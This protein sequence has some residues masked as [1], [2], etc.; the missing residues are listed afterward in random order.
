MGGWRVA[1]AEMIERVECVESRVLAAHAQGGPW[2]IGEL[3][4]VDIVETD[5]G[6]FRR[7]RDSTFR[8]LDSTPERLKATAASV[9]QKSALE[10]FT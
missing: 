6:H 8:L 2:R 5:H 10:W 9:G 4:Q 3:G 1:L 7:N